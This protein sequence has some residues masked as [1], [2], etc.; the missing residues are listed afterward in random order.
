M[1]VE[2]RTNS[3]LKLSWIIS[4]LAASSCSS[5]SRSPDSSDGN[6]ASQQEEIQ[7]L[8][9]DLNTRL[10]SMETKLV[11][12]ND[13]VDSTRLSLDQLASRQTQKQVEVIEHPSEQ[14]GA[15]ALIK[16]APQDP[17]AGLAHDDVIQT[18]RKAMIFFQGQ[19]YP[20]A[21]LAFSGFLE[22]SPDHPLAGSAQYY[23]AESYMLQKE[24]KLAEQEFHRMLTSYDRSIHIADALRQLAIAEENL[25]K[26]QEAAKHRQQL[27]SLFPQSPAARL[28]QPKMEESNTQPTLTTD[29][30]PNSTQPVET[31]ATPPQ[32]AEQ[33][34]R[35]AEQP[36]LDQPPLNPAPPTAPLEEEF[37]TSQ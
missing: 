29:Q 32:L 9:A 34:Q 24:Y 16:T 5:P 6:R 1:S 35:L 30:G 7:K 3:V 37:K 11:S 26:P 27:T 28:P 8:M 31:K 2:I 25:K 10:Q 33:P 15:P 18:F 12:L 20:E 36:Q 4:L 23:V 22:K 21:I 17:E 19:K 14:S 13:K